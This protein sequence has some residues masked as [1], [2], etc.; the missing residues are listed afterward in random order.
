M[1]PNLRKNSPDLSKP[2]EG[3][4]FNATRKASES[5][6]PLQGLNISSER[7]LG[8]T[9]GI[10]A[11]G[12]LTV[13]I[14]NLLPQQGVEF[15]LDATN[16]TLGAGAEIGSTRGKLGVNIGAKVGYDET[17]KLSIKAASA[18]INIAGIGGSASLDEREGTQVSISVAGASLGVGLSPDG[19]PSLTI[20]YAVPGGSVEIKFEPPGKEVEVPPKPFVTELP[21]ELK[22]SLEPIPPTEFPFVTS[23]PPI[24]L[25]VTVTP[26]KAYI[27]TEVDEN[28]ICR[29]VV[30]V[31]KNT[32]EWRW[33]MGPYYGEGVRTFSESRT[34]EYDTNGILTGNV[35]RI[36]DSFYYVYYRQSDYPGID[37]TPYQINRKTNSDTGYKPIL[38]RP[39]IYPWY[40]PIKNY[41]Y[42][43]TTTPFITR[44]LGVEGVEEWWG[45][46][47]AMYEAI[48]R[49][50]KIS[51]PIPT[52]EVPNVSYYTY[53]FIKAAP[54]ITQYS[55]EAHYCGNEDVLKNPNL[56][57][58]P[59]QFKP[60]ECCDKVNEIY[61]YLGIAKLKKNKFKVARQFL[62]PRTAGNEECEDYYSISEALFKMLANGL[63]INPVSKPLGSEWQNVNATAWASEIY[64]M[65]AEAKSDGNSTQVFELHAGFQLVQL[66]KVLAELTRKVEFLSEALGYMPKVESESVPVMFTIHESHKGFGQKE[67]K[68]IDI[69]KA[70]TDEQVEK[71][72]GKMLAPSKIP[73]TKWVFDPNHKSIN[74]AL[75]NR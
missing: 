31:S 1:P 14:E 28:R 72:L 5:T 57:N 12:K 38:P 21:P 18:G 6:N 69:T 15:E 39:S 49:L 3:A 47:K 20:G 66:A 29:I 40:L 58:P 62:V 48:D 22:Q 55:I 46:E 45:Y 32:A 9:N 41:P 75:N 59:Q 36:I 34:A 33:G 35:R 10:K 68:E 13:G 51:P 43:K 26:P 8:S 70:K 74:E 17:G 52:T 60:M 37:L 54:A 11:T 16:R 67:L 73:I 61:K 2:S 53:R 44:N 7:E 25:F 42:L 4:S 56:P 30:S 63:I 50:C 27:P 65:I 19:K 23:E 24:P 71:I 64:E